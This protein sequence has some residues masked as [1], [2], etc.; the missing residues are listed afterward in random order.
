M[1]G[2]TKQEK[3]GERSCSCRR[4][5]RA[6]VTYN[7]GAWSA[8]SPDRHTTNQHETDTRSVYVWPW[9]SNREDTV[10]PSIRNAVWMSFTCNQP[11]RG[12]PVC[13]WELRQDEQCFAGNSSANFASD[14]T[15][16][17]KAGFNIP[18]RTV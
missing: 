18:I 4:G 7:G 11:V 8:K 17:R 14:S 16:A 6:T 9:Q 1:T 12:T 15:G 3:E 5:L 10:V 13:D 2:D